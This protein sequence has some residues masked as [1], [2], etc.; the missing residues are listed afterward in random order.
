MREQGTNSRLVVL[1]AGGTGGHLFPAQALA[2]A[3]VR[4][5]YAIH[6]MT[7]ER[8][9]DYGRAFPALETHLVPAATITPSKPFLLPL[10]LLKLYRGYRAA[11]A[12]LARLKPVALAG[13]GGYPSFPPVI[14]AS[15]LGIP[16]CIHD[17]NAVMGRAN[18]VLSRYADAVASSFP[19]LGKL[20]EECKSKLRYTGNPVR[21][22]VLT[23]QG[24]PYQSSAADQPFNLLVFG[25]S[26]G[27]RFFAEFMPEVLKLL[28]KAVL[29]NLKVVQQCRPEDIE[30]VK[31]AYGGLELSFELASFF[32]DMPQRIAD[33]QLVICRS[34]ASTIAELGVIG[35]PAVMVPLPHALDNDQLANAE[36]LAQKG[37]GWVMPQADL[38]PQE[39]AAFL[40][41]LRYQDDELAGAARAAL[42]L[43]MPDAAERLADV[44]EE[45]AH[46]PKIT[47]M[48]EK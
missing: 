29:R 43:G 41:R 2:E 16:C 35:R 45:L 30:R 7:D 24:D 48:T 46:R 31:A 44:V 10:Q 34:G 8:V 14:A 37:G 22:I 18:R 11:R 21:G 20:P 26:Q 42:A 32:A 19:T 40:T 6:L 27:A 9:R 33:A 4:R 1:A 47:E 15:R 28:P 39:F 25:G 13:F 17:Q 3:L 38:T 23:K 36:F 5:G 12:V